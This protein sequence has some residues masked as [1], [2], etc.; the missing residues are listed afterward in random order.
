[1]AGFP[2][3]VV[4]AKELRILR[5]V[6]SSEC[7]PWHLGNTLRRLPQDFKVCVCGQDVSLHSKDFPN[8]DWANINIDRRINFFSDFFALLRLCKLCINYQPDIIHSIMPKASLLAAIAGFVCRVPVRFH[9]FTG[10]VW[11]T[12]FGFSKWIF[13]WIDRIVV[14]LNT[15]CF[16]DSPSQSQ[17]LFENGISYDGEPL[18]VLGIGSLGGV[19]LARFDM[20]RIR[21]Y[22]K[23]LKFELGIPD[24]HF[25]FS[26]IARKTL[27][28]G[29]I[30][31]LLAFNRVLKDN[32]Y[33]HLLFVG[34]DETDGLL[35][36]MQNNQP[37][38]FTNVVDIGRVTNHEMYLA[39][40]NVLCLPSYREGFGTIVI[41]AAA[42]SVPT[43][44]SNIVGLVDSI[45]DGKTGILFTAGSIDQLAHAMLACSLDTESTHQLGA[46]A[47]KKVELHFTA[48]V[49][50][51]ALK[52]CYMR[53][54]Q[55]GEKSQ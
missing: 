21:N 5:V 11:A 52:E 3:I 41:D 38:T 53:S 47:R 20:D 31:I 7:V 42:M 10:Q 33:V 27:D 35:Q 2:R 45:E 12:E 44:G 23:R 28:K 39:I 14:L 49:M 6:T 48:D 40:S 22:G 34:P 24:S 36:E 16:T 4:V 54:L 46:A 29:C 17:Y 15:Q 55:V 51:I 9:T 8:V 26:F 43:I 50:Y 19:D 18:P 13:Y 32:P 37:D 1:M 30:D 25:I